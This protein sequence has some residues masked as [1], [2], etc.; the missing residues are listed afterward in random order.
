MTKENK[1]GVR[2]IGIGEVLRRIIAKLLIGLI[3]DDI[4]TAAGPLQ[5]CAGLKGGIE[6]AIH[7]MRQTY[8]K[9]DTE[10]ML[11][12]DAENAFNNINRKVALQNIKQ[13][14]PPFYQYLFNTYQK[15]ALLV[16]P[17]EKSHETIYSEEGC[18]QGDVNAMALY[19]IGLSPLVTRLSEVIDRQSCVQSC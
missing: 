14:C 19:G 18:T 4:I 11:L 13:I 17:G 10:A 6:A 16:I 9:S 5:T 8:E 3:K 2:P 1:P 12:V 15:P 7:A